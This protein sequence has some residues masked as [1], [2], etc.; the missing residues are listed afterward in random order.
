MWWI[1][2]IIVGV[3]GGLIYLGKRALELSDEDVEYLAR[4]V[5]M[6]HA[7]V[8]PGEEWAGIMWVALNRAAGKGKTVREVVV[9][10]AWPGG[11]A[12]GQAYV[13]AIQQSGGEGYRSGY[14]H[15]APPDSSYWSEALSFARQVVD[16]Q[17]DNPIGPRKHFFHPGGMPG[18]GNLAEGEW[19]ET[20]SRCCVDGRLWPAW[21]MPEQ[22][23]FPPIRVGTAVFS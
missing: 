15:R 1:V 2:P 12:R 7:Q 11:G 21:G 4:V 3:V 5:I 8:G 6:E 19:N 22:A 13:E 14:G 10:S 18:C 17:V 9:T 23:E 20:G 16:R